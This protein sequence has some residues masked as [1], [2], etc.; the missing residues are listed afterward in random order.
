MF[1]QVYNVNL[2]PILSCIMIFITVRIKIII[3]TASVTITLMIYVTI[4]TS[5]NL[6]SNETETFLIPMQR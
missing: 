2:L 5:M 3:F 6:I 4:D 1:L